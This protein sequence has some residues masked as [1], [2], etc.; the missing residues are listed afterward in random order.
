M[1][2][3]DDFRLTL[4]LS[5]PLSFCDRKLYVFRWSETWNNNNSSAIHRNWMHAK[6][7][8]AECCWNSIISKYSKLLH[9]I[10]LELGSFYSLENMNRKAV[11]EF[12]ADS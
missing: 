12:A 2:G 10:E 3:I 9:S 1:D 7:E 8:S 6:R 11:L 4:H 5:L